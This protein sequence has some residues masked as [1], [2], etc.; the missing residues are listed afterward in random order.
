MEINEGR[1]NRRARNDNDVVVLVKEYI[2]SSELRQQP[3]LVTCA[4][5]VDKYPLVTNSFSL[6]F[7]I[8][9]T[10]CFDFQDGKRFVI[11]EFL[12]LCHVLV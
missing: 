5:D 1:K 8:T 11:L 4:E 3:M 2:C 10:H 9:L 12:W 7:V 6:R